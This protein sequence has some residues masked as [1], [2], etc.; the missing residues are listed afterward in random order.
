MSPL[1]L[2]LFVTWMLFVIGVGF[3]FL[4]WAW[5]RGEYQFASSSARQ[6]SRSSEAQDTLQPA[7]VNCSARAITRD[8]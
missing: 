1:G 8:A 4:L 2:C 7:S 3:A 5:K 6:N